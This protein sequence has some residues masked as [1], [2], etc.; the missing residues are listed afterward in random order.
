MYLAVAPRS[1]AEQFLKL[2]S[3]VAVV[4]EADI[5]RDLAHGIVTVH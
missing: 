1:H 5:L 4:V 3:K 2:A